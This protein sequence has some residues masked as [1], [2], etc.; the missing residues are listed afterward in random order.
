MA[1]NKRI[2]NEILSKN[3]ILSEVANFCSYL[4]NNGNDEKILQLKK[5]I[6]LLMPTEVLYISVNDATDAHVVDLHRGL[7]PI[8]T[9]SSF[10]LTV[11]GWMNW[12]Y[13]VGEDSKR[14]NCRKIK[15]KVVNG[16]KIYWISFF[17]AP[18]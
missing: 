1:F 15:K 16:G 7:F 18:N 17:I 10:N 13:V 4:G 6:I 2:L 8:S 3:N 14:I 5:R 11:D 9:S 12:G